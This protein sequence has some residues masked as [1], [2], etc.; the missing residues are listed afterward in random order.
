VLAL[1]PD[2]RQFL[3]SFALRLKPFDSAI[4]KLGEPKGNPKR[5]ADGGFQRDYERGVA[6]FNPAIN[7][8]IVVMLDS[9]HVD[10]V[11]DDKRQKFV[12]NSPG[13][14]ILLAEG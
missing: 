12:V 4:E 14:K 1:V 13:G 3:K 2:G 5:R 9:E 10:P 8:N 7:N 6:I 11:R